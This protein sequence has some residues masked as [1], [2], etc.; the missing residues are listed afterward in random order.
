MALFGPKTV[1]E[2]VKLLEDAVRGL[3]QVADQQATVAAKAAEQI[4]R[5]ERVRERALA[6]S[7]RAERI[8]QKIEEL[9]K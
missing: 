2:A 5:T 1:D 3:D 6:E 9:L 8:S 4:E 7:L